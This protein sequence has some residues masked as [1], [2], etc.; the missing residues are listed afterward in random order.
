MKKRRPS[1]ES[2]HP[3]SEALDLSSFA[4]IVR[5]L[6]VEDVAAVSAVRKVLPQIARVAAVAAEAIRVGGRLIYVGAGTSG[7][8]GVLDAAEVPPTFGTEPWQV[9]GVIAG[10]KAALTRSVEGAEDD[11]LAGARAV[12]ALRA[13]PSDLVC[14]IT[15]SGTTPFVLG[16]LAQ[17]RRARATTALVCCNPEASAASAAHLVVA[18]RTGPELVAGSTRLKAG[19]ATKLVLN[20]IST[21]AMVSLGRVYR[22]RMVDVAPTNRKLE[23]RARAI[24]ADLTGLS[25]ARAAALLARAKGSPRVAIAMHLTGDSAEAA[26]RRLRRVGLRALEPRRPPRSPRA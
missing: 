25:P 16:A 5:L 15:A 4:E 18:P 10:G 26:E 20:A 24:V 12:R 7:R 21:A 13:G 6:H 17:A 9:V 19:T 22:G 23:G 1:T 3:R 14:G 11:A 2:V 8:L